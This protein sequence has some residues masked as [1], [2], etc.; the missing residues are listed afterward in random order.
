MWKLIKSTR[1]LPVEFRLIVDPVIQR[2]AYFAHPENLLLSMLSDENKTV[3]ELAARRIL[4]ARS[5]PH[6]EKVPRVFEVPQINFDANNYIDLIYWQQQFFD[7][8]I[9]RHIS[10]QEI[11]E[12]I[13]SQGD[14]NLIFLKLPCHTQAVERSVKI[15]TEASMSLCDKKSR[16]GLIQA[17]L[18][19]R[20]LM[21]RFE[22]KR[23]FVAKI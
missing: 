10:N 3:R 20:K 7:P 11:N 19:S 21:P 23:D 16:E 15:V 13:E 4:Q 5:S 17:K 6:T 9:L 12:V 2:N 1:Y 14:E 18:A 8:P 22:S